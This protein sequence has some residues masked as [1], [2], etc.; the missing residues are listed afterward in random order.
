MHGAAS[1]SPFSLWLFVSIF[2]SLVFIPSFIHWIAV[3]T[4]HFTVSLLLTVSLLFGV[5]FVL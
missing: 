2:I 5:S 1:P 4:W 3:F